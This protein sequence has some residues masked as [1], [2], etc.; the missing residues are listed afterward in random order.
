M[1]VTNV[2]RCFISTPLLVPRLKS[3]RAFKSLLLESKLQSEPST[4]MILCKTAL[5]WCRNGSQS[6]IKGDSSK[7]LNFLDI[8]R[9]LLTG[10][11]ACI[12]KVCE[13]KTNTSLIWL[14]IYN[15]PRIEFSNAEMCHTLEGYDHFRIGVHFRLTSLEVRGLDSIIYLSQTPILDRCAVKAR[16]KNRTQQDCMCLRRD[17]TARSTNISHSRLSNQHKWEERPRYIYL[18]NQHTCTFDYH[19]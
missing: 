7:E 12:Y 10:M 5:S 3:Q 4:T 1:A 9:F 17:W 11:H 2:L 13:P 19:N 16:C 18:E 15:A 6:E 8:D 14:P